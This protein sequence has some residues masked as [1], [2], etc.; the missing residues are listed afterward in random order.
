M[1]FEP[2]LSFVTRPKPE[3]PVLF[4][5]DTSGSMSFP[6]VQNGPTRIQSVWQALQP[7]LGKLDEHF[8][9]RF[10]TFDTD[11]REL[12]KP[13]DLARLTADGK[14]TDLVTGLKKAFAADARGDDAVAV[15]ISDG[16]DNTNANVV[17]AMAALDR[18]VN[19]V[20]VGSDAAEAAN[21]AN[22]AVADVAGR[23]RFRRRARVAGHGRHQ[24]VGAGQPRGGGEPRRGGRQGQA[25][26]QP[27]C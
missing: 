4:V 10:F 17:E 26:R 22:I 13:E 27:R 20:L 2:V 25:D 18:R 15:L 3:K 24:V 1:L 19:T 21:L 12:K 16:N 11:A 23:R 6:D 8:V 14:A 9:P 7:Q 5:I